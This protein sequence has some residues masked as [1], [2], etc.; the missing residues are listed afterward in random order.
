MGSV[1][2]HARHYQMT[3]IDTLRYSMIRVRPERT[4]WI[5]DILF[6]MSASP[7][8]ASASESSCAD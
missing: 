5:F 8:A 7:E 2:S 3:R 4:I 6:V 1:E